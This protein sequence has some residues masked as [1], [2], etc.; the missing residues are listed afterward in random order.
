MNNSLPTLWQLPASHFSEKAR[1]ALDHKR[2]AHR[3]RSPVPGSH[4]P[5]AAALTRGRA[6]TFPILRMDG[7][8][9][10]GSSAIVAA[11]E[12][13]HPEAALFPADPEERR[14]AL[15]LEAY[16][17]EEL[18][19]GARLFAFHEMG[20]DRKSLESLMEE[21]APGPL[22]KIPAVSA[23]YGRVFTG[24]RFGVHDEQAAQEARQTLLDTLDRIER[25]LGDG[26]Y[27]VG[28]KFSV[29]DLAAASLFFPIVLPPEGPVP[30][31]VTPARGVVEFRQPLL[32]RRGYRYLEEMYSRHRHQASVA[33]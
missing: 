11:L 22:A 18:G 17:D 10:V 2:V 21:S 27:L 15:A 29:A 25:E 14:R 1:W 3:R 26:E 23:T 16:F 31:T 24:L 4:M 13:S 7:R 28:E 8:T 9:I 20:K 33:A 5:I 19:P 32:D 6:N 30:P 12:Q